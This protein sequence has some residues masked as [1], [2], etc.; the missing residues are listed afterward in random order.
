[1]AAKGITYDDILRDLKA[2][3]VAPVYYLMGDEDYFIDKLSDAIVEAVLTEDEK[4]FNLDILYG[5]EAEMDK[6]IELAR[7]YPMMAEKRVVLVREAQAMRSIEGLETY[8]AHLTPTTV[9][10]FCH[11]HGKLDTRKAAA[12]AIQQVGVI[13]ESKRLY[14]NQVASFISQYLHKHNVDV[15]PQAIQMLAS[16]V[17]SDLSRLTTEMDKL[18]LALNGGRVVGASLVEEQTGVSKDFNDFELQSALAQRNIFRA[19][20]IVKYYQGNPRSFFITRTLTNL[21]TFFS[22]VMLAFYAPEK[23]DA[24]IAAWLG[25]PEWKIRMDIGPARRNYSGVKV[26]Q[27]LSEIRKTDAQSKG[28][29]GI[30]TPHEEL[31]QDLIFF[32]LH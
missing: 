29:G 12:K 24:G 22:D 1:M 7:A 19:N 2:K 31:L 9:L 17:G 30:R 26:M 15:E 13:Y 8:L 23:N 28:V 10:I 16:H 4:D 14:D 27:I 3:K 11:K 18:L 20:Q 32:I 21:F 5:A 25:K 6:V